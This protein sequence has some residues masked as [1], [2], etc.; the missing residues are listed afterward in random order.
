MKE[1]V[2]VAKEADTKKVFSPTRS[3]E[4]IHRLRDEPERQLG[5]LRSV[6]GTIRRDGGTPSVDSIANEL[7]GMPSS[8][9]RASV[10]LALQRTHGN[11]YVQRVVAGIQAKLKVGQPGE[12]YEQEADRIADAVMLMPESQVQ[13][14][15]KGKEEEEEILQTKEIS[16][17]TPELEFR[18]QTLQGSGQPL[19][20]S[21]RAFFESRFGY[22]FSRVR[23]HAD[24]Q[25]AEAARSVNARA[26]TI[27]RDV[28]FGAGQYAPETATGQRLVAHELTHV[29][30]QGIGTS[31]TKIQRVV[32][33]DITQMSITVDWARNL[34]DD[35]L[36]QQI[37]IVRDQLTTLSSRTPEFEAA[38]SNLQ[39]LEQEVSHPGRAAP[40]PTRMLTEWE[41]SIASRSEYRPL[42]DDDG[43]TLLGYYM[44]FGG[45]EEVRD[46]LGNVAWSDAIGLESPI[47]SPIDFVGSGLIRVGGCLGV[48]F[49]TRFIS[50][51]TARR[52]ASGISAG[53]ASRMGRAVIDRLRETASRITTR[54]TARAA[55]RR[56]TSELVG[57]VGRLTQAEIRQ[58]ITASG[59]RTITLYTK[60]TQAP[61]AGR[62][63]SVATEPALAEAA[64]EGGQIFVARVPDILFH[65]METI[66]V[67]I[68]SRTLMGG[69]VG[70]EIRVLPQ[71]AETIIRFIVP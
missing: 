10:L 64:R 47:L 51:V 23:I 7:G 5:S 17:K 4:G 58:A 31:V 52:V 8:T 36:E 71:A 57:P 32:E 43:R 61:V 46:R 13:L 68:R 27:G 55:A 56:A 12:I 45:Y 34:E 66:G 22:D 24:R 2:A 40:E 44:S 60:L 54:I 11:R 20:E 38:R 3:D 62:A 28:V 42:F 70:T 18:I 49:V 15:G 9:Q 21:T 30:Q 1:S 16:S 65:G 25:A 67:I 39:I 50:R 63:I 41:Q 37:E 29:V 59:G 33:G 53:A 6:I 35:E 14:Q 19:P 26:F 69:V 48:R